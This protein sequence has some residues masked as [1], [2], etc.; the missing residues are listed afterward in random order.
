[1]ALIKTILSLHSSSLKEMLI[2]SVGGDSSFLYLEGV[3]SIE[4]E[5]LL[6]FLYVGETK[7]AKD[8]FESF[9]QLTHNLG[10]KGSVSAEDMEK[11]EHKVKEPVDEMNVISSLD[12]F[13]NSDFSS[14]FAEAYTLQKEQRL[15]DCNECDYSTTTQ[16]YLK[17]HINSVHMKIK[18]PCPECDKQ[19]AQRSS[20]NLHLRSIHQGIS[21]P[22]QYCDYSA[23]TR[24]NLKL[25]QRK[26]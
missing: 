7:I 15:F 6:N 2:N 19:F 11:H 20:M 10:V 18:H 4:I 22:C 8:H 12:E 21:Y 14:H 16:P 23:S 9:V 25:H 26:H 1:M 5:A 3:S 24:G 13:C 17:V